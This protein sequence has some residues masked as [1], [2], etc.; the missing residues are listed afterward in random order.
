MDVSRETLEKLEVYEALVKKWTASV[1][2][3]APS[4][5]SDHWDRHIVDYQQ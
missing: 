4:T 2:L 3:I 1:N 5:V